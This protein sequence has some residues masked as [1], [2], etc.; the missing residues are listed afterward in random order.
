MDP[1]AINFIPLKL[2][3][4]PLLWGCLGASPGLRFTSILNKFDCNKE[5]VILIFLF[6]PFCLTLS[7]SQGFIGKEAFALL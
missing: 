3:F 7:I 5:S 6:H 4:A 2:I 1:S